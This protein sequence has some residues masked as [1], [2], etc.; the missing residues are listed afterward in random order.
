MFTPYAKARKV[1]EV[2]LFTN[3]GVYGN[4]HISFCQWPGDMSRVVV[5]G[6]E[7]TE[8]DTGNLPIRTQH[9]CQST[10]QNTALLSINQSGDPSEVTEPAPGGSLHCYMTVT[11]VPSLHNCPACVK[12][13][14]SYDADDMAA[15]WSVSTN[16]N[17]H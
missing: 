13:A 9:L 15:A 2:T 6:Y 14:N 8:S 5:Y 11:A 10:N 12:V 3:Q 17:H 7:A 4:L 1:A 16:Q